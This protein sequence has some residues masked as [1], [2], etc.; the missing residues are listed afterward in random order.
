MGCFWLL[1]AQ[2]SV[3]AI[4]AVQFDDDAK[5]LRY[6][7][8][9]DEIR[10][11]KCQNQNLSGSNSAIAIDLRERVAELINEGKSDE[12]VRTYM[13]KRYGDFV[14]YRPPM[15]RNTVLLWWAPVF[16][17]AVGLSVFLLIVWRRRQA[18]AGRADAVPA[19]IDQVADVDHLDEPSSSTTAT[20]RN[21]P[22][23]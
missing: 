9:V 17:G 1:F 10:C 8:L 13:V 6:Q 21:P 22:E 4:D 7:Q 20:K 11:P 16:M 12:Q 2:F 23:S 15:Q 3:A 5:R 14:L 19:D 18:Y